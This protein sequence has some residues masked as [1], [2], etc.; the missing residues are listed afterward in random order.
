[1]CEENYEHVPKT[2]I[3]W[4]M[5]VV[6]TQ[7]TFYQLINAIEEDTLRNTMDKLQAIQDD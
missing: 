2:G 5:I 6:H 1:M 4:P 7:D 3:L